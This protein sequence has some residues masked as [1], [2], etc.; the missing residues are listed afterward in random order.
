MVLGLLVNQGAFWVR[1]LLLPALATA[2]TLTT[3]NITNHELFSIKKTPRPVL[4]SL[5][6]NNVVMSGTMLLLTSWLINDDAISKGFIVVAAMPPATSVVPF[7]HTLGGDVVFSLIGVAGLYLIA[8]GL[9]PGMMIVLLGADFLNP[10][11][12]LLTLVYL[13][14]I[15]L[16]ISRLL[17]LKGLQKNVSKWQSKAITWCYFTTVYTIVG[18]NRQIFFEQPDI[19]LYALII[20][21]SVT[22]ILGQA[23][24]FISRKLHRDHANSISFSVMGTRK[25]TGLASAIAL[26]FLG[27]RASFPA[28]ICTLVQISYFVWQ[29]LYYKKRVT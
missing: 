16:I 21:I 9:T 17:I 4:I 29:G 12:L 24:Y 28:A 18:L 11:R 13:I 14:V 10:M 22:F 26:T 2:M 25:N 5:L 23:I 1:P 27:Q 19:L 15:P 7:S 6:L 3:I 20:A 8:L